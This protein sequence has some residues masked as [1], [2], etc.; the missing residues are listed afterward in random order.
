[1]LFGILVTI[2]LNKSFSVKILF[3]LNWRLAVHSDLSGLIAQLWK[4]ESL[5]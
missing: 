1:M 4:H 5:F 3:S 2:P